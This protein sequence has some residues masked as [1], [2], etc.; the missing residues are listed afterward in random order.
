MVG[1]DAPEFGPRALKVQD[2]E[3]LVVLR[4]HLDDWYLGSKSLVKSIPR[5]LRP[6]YLACLRQ[7]CRAIVDFQADTEERRTL[8]LLEK[9][10]GVRLQ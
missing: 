5:L 7:A 2:L 8:A 10:V 1:P 4:D 3:K 9:S 6:L